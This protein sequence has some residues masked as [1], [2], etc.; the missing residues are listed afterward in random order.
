MK[1]PSHSAGGHQSNGTGGA[2]EAAAVV[3]VGSTKKESMGTSLSGR[4]RPNS[5]RVEAAPLCSDVMCD[6][7]V[8]RRGGGNYV[9]S[10]GGFGG[11]SPAGYGEGAQEGGRHGTTQRLSEGS[12][13][14]LRFLTPREDGRGPGKLR[15]SEAGHGREWNRGTSAL[16][17]PMR[18]EG[19]VGCGPPG[20]HSTTEGQ[21]LS[22]LVPAERKGN[23]KEKIVGWW[24]VITSRKWSS[25]RLPLGE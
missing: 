17:P 5:S 9:I 20:T 11:E 2:E 21:H 4:S 12:E 25:S 14:D 23:E 10:G 1:S 15:P 7:C 22:A 13:R 8:C 16:L 24:V 18:I 19:C 6:V 3:V